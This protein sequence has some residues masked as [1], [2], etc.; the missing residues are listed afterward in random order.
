VSVNFVSGFFPINYVFISNPKRYSQFYDGI[1]GNG[2]N[3]KVIVTSN[4]TES[5]H[6][7]DYIFNYGKLCGDVDVTRDNPLIMF[8]NLLK[9]IDVSN[10][11]LAGF[12]GFKTN[13]E[14]NYYGDYIPFLYCNEDV[15]MRNMAIKEYIKNYRLVKDIKFLTES[16]YD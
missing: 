15:T 13:N 5:S 10:I 1:Y 6:K 16:I 14:D 4:V 12:D 11:T 7:I 2:A 9:D 8:M 3:P